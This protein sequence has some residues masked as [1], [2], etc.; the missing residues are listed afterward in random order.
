MEWQPFSKVSER[1]KAGS[2]SLLE[3]T[4]LHVPDQRAH[5]IPDQRAQQ[6]EQIFGQVEGPLPPSSVVLFTFFYRVQFFHPSCSRQIDLSLS[7]L[8]V[9]IWHH[10]N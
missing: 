4:G 1:E 3:N 5:H 9:M 2:T 7:P 8:R 6:I 10:P